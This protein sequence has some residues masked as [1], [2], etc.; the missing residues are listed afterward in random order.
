MQ[1]RISQVAFSADENALV[2]SSENGGGLAVYDV[3][4]FDQRNTK[5][6]FEI[7]TNGTAL[8]ELVPNPVKERAELFA[9][10]T[11]EGQ[12]LLANLGSKRLLN[13]PNGP[14]LKQQVSCVSWSSKGKQLVVGLGDGKAHQMTP[15]GEGQGDIPVPPDM[16]TGDQRH[17]KKI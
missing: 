11:V 12:L 13:G 5:P 2:I 10:V 6:A 8:R 4:G 3:S 9:M 17:G 14:V 1:F 7:S 16:A 15:G